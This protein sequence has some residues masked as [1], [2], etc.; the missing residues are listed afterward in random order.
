MIS[1]SKIE[2]VNVVLISHEAFMSKIVLKIKNRN[3]YFSL[4]NI[5]LHF[6]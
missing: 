5:H 3:L 6:L 1:I 4:Q 2:L